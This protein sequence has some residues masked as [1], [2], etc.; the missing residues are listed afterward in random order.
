[1]T[2][3]D[4]F[5]AAMGRLS[6]AERRTVLGNE[7]LVYP[8][9]EQLG[10]DSTPPDAVAFATMGVDGVHYLILKL[11]GQI[12]DDSPVIHFSPMDSTSPYALLG[13]TFAEYLAATCGVETK[14]IRKLIELERAGK[15]VLAGFLRDHFDHGRLDLYG[16]GS[17]I[18]EYADLLPPV[19]P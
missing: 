3:F 17:R 11:D 7:N 8:P 5:V 2:D 12:R 18:S 13:H 4:V 1:M 14:E 15:P 10:Y 6:I 19:D 16:F 9:D